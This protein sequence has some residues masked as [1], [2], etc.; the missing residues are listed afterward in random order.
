MLVAELTDHECWDALTELAAGAGE[1]ELTARFEQACETEWEHLE[2]VR[3]WIAAG[4]GRRDAD[5]KGTA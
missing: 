1:R 4:Q 3:A 2:K 5:G